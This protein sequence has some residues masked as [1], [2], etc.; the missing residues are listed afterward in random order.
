MSQPGKKPGQLRAAANW[1]YVINR[2]IGR[3]KDAKN[4]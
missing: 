3:D 2:Q 4:Y 1:L